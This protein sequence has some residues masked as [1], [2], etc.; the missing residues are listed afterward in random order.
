ML[1]KCASTSHQADI[2]RFV[3]LAVT[4]KTSPLY[5]PRKSLSAGVHFL[6]KCFLRRSPRL[7]SPGFLLSLSLPRL[8]LSRSECFREIFRFARCRLRFQRNFLFSS[9]KNLEGISRI[10]FDYSLVSIT[11]DREWNF[12]FGVENDLHSINYVDLVSN[13]LANNSTCNDLS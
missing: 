5:H 7:S 12:S 1:A 3:G 13:R 6:S 2:E 4:I 11:R 8:Y 10:L 9:E